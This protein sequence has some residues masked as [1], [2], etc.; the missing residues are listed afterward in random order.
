MGWYE[1]FRKT[2]GTAAQQIKGSGQPVYTTAN[3]RS[4]EVFFTK[5]AQATMKQW[6]LSEKDAL[7]VY[8]HSPVV[9]NNMMVKKHNGYEIGIWFFAD[10]ISGKPMISSVWKR[11]RR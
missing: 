6:G 11:G 2:I 10:R 1:E 5:N 7:D 3:H 9:K 8:H 4:R